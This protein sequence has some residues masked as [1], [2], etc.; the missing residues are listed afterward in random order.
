MRRGTRLTWRAGRARG[1]ALGGII[2]ILFFA[3][4]FGGRGDRDATPQPAPA[5]APAPPV[6]RWPAPPARAEPAPLVEAPLVTQPVARAEP[7]SVADVPEPAPAAEPVVTV[8]RR[9]AGRETIRDGGAVRSFVGSDP[10]PD[11]AEDARRAKERVDAARAAA[12]AEARKAEWNRKLTA[13]VAALAR[14]LD[15]TRAKGTAKERVAASAAWNK[16]RQSLA[17]READAVGRHRAVVAAE[18]RLR[19]A[20]EVLRDVQRRDAEA[21]AAEHARQI[22]EQQA[23]WQASREAARASADDE[24]ED[25]GGGYGSGGSGS[26]GGGRVHVRGYTRKDGTYVR[27]HTRSRPRR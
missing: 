9:P 8:P 10:T 13:E 3:W 14:R 6:A 12:L 27:P 21:R 4:L 15:Q 26:S 20:T 18:Q 19:E 5:P 17:A 1:S 2:I 24:E 23:A 11:P 25:Y 16:A 22:A 7:R